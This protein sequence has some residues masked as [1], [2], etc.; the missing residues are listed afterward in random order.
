MRV[1]LEET[2]LGQQP[3]DRRMGLLGVTS[4]KSHFTP[5]TMRGRARDLPSEL[6]SRRGLPESRDYTPRS[7]RWV[8]PN[9][10]Q[11]PPGFL[12]SNSSE[13]AFTWLRRENEHTAVMFSTVERSVLLLGEPCSTLPTIEC[14]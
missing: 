2:R 10:S 8:V 9:T 3:P 1:L 13:S 6:R 4:W 7:Q 11:P 5:N 12:G 14:L